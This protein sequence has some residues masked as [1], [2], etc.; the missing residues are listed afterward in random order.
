MPGKLALPRC[1]N[2]SVR[3]TRINP[4]GPSRDNLSSL[5]TGVTR[6][7]RSMLRSGLS[8]YGFNINII[9]EASQAGACWTPSAMHICKPAAC[10]NEGWLRKKNGPHE[11]PKSREE[12]PKEGMRA[13][14]RRHSRA[15]IWCAESKRARIRLSPAW[16]FCSSVADVSSAFPPDRAA[17]QSVRPGQELQ[18]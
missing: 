4:C 9:N 6:A 7:I 13:A 2:L 16:L 12:T 5:A 14:N 15:K 3:R 1:N 18:P 10:N 11:R 17:G 8:P